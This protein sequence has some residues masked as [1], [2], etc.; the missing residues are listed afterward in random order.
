MMKRVVLS[1]F[2]VTVTLAAGMAMAAECNCGEACS[3]EGT[4]AE[5]CS[6]EAAVKN[7]FD[8][9]L[10]N[11]EGKEVKLADYEGKVLLFVNVASK[12]G[13]TPQYEGLVKLQKKYEEKGLVVMGFPANNYGGQEP[14]TNEEI[15][16]FCQTNYDVNFPMSQKISVKGEDIHPLFDYLTKLENPDFTGPIKWNFEKFLIGRDGELMH[17]FRSKATPM[18]EEIITAVEKAI[19]MEAPNQAQ[20][21]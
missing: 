5:G 20:T 9:K 1:L 4:C 2:V 14:G 19:E 16:Q 18:G 21:G 15:M 10:K 17:R 3:A 13:Y 7:V 6:C 12:C 11:I 8:F